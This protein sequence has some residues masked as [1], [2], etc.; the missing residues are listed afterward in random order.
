MIRADTKT[1]FDAAAILVIRYRY[2][3]VERRAGQ[4]TISWFVPDSNAARY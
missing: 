2:M 1:P 4:G 3:P